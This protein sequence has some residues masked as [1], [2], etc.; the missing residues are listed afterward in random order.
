MVTV[1]PST[2]AR[3]VTAT[4]QGTKGN[5]NQDTVA[6]AAVTTVLTTVALNATFPHLRPFPL[7]VGVPCTLLNLDHPLPTCHRPCRAT[8]SVA[9]T[10][11][12]MALTDLQGWT[13]VAVVATVPAAMNA[14]TDDRQQLFF[15]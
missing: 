9:T 4:T 10:H 11:L 7:A 1:R 12:R 14:M 2:E 15:N 13:K 3:R 8:D 5:T 6:A